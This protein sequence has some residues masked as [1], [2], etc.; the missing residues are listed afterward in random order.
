[1]IRTLLR[2]GL[3]RRPASARRACRPIVESLE[4][5]LTPS[6]G[7]AAQQTFATGLLPT[8]IVAA[9]FN[10]DGRPDFAVLNQTDKTAGVS[11]NTTPSGSGTA[12]FA[13]QKTFAVGG[14][15]FGVAAADVNGDGRPDLA[16]ANFNEK[17]VGVLLNTTP[18]GSGMAAFAAQQSFATGTSPF[19]VAAADVNGDGRPD[20][21]VTN[22]TDKTVSV[23]LNTT[24]AGSATAAFAAQQTFATGAGPFGVAAA[25]VNGDGRPDLAVANFSDKSVSVLLNTTLSGSGTAAFAAQQTFAIGKNPFGVAAADVNGDG[26]PDLAV[27]NQGDKT[28]SVLLNATAATTAAFAAQQTFATGTSP[29]GVTAADLDGDGRPDLAAADQLDKTVS[30]LLNATAAGATTAAFAARQTFATGT[31]P[32]LLA[33]ADFNTDGRPDLAVTNLADNTASVLL[34]AAAPFPSAVPVVVG[35]FGSQGVWELNRSLNTWVQLTPANATLLAAD[36]LGDVAGV[37]PGF[38]VQEFRPT[39]GWRQ[40]NGIDATVLAMNAQGV[41]VA[42]FPGFGVGEFVPAFG[43]RLLTGAN[44]SLL[45]IDDNAD[46]AGEIQ[47]FGV[48]L[49]RPASGWSQINGVDASLLAL[50]PRGDV[51]ANFHGFGVGEFSLATGWH[52]LNGTQATA[53]AIDRYGDVTAQFAGVGVGYFAPAFGW[54]LL[55]GANA[56]LL[57]FDALGDVIGEFPGFG[58]WEFDAFRGWFQLTGAN[59][60]FLATG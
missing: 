60:T 44:A 24:A 34:D 18:S 12:A 54:R 56:S 6:F 3:R 14:Q 38:G 19:G 15:I 46:V 28:V 9:D 43:W 48:W 55:T 11:L 2:A 51:V 29:T 47:G 10:T 8:G 21:V 36:S 25:D 40:I 17:T 23:L 41:V 53:L 16:V 22:S 37:F 30:V 59:A 31:D 39:G 13:A 49:F 26:R 27:T 50:S 57:R 45:S 52:L 5:R 20:L 42:E 35:Q 58:V 33:A 7:L 4:T 32:F 1:M